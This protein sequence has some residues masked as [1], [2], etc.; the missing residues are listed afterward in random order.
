MR[1]IVGY[2]DTPSG[3]DALNLAVRLA[4]S[5][6]RSL[7]IVI[8]LRSEARAT[9]V[10][11]DAGYEKYLHQAAEEW[12]HHALTLVPRDMDVQGHIVYAESF[13]QGLLDASR[14]LEGRM[15][16]V[17]AARGGLLG[18]FTIGSVANALLHSA[19][20]P[21]ALAPEGSH[22]E[23]GLEGISRVTVAVG[24]RSGAKELVDAGILAAR[25][26]G[27]PLRLVSLVAL[28][29]DGVDTPPEVRARAEEHAAETVAYA[30]EHLPDDIEVT[31][32]TASGNRI[33]DAVAAL[34]WD[35]GE[36]VF[37]GSSRLAQP[38]QI[39]LG[40]TAAKMLRELPV[41][42][43]VVPRDSILTV[44]D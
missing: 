17:G 41:P 11:V 8:V 33:E 38:R 21:V 30:A 42:M 16:I 24:T 31:V 7:D 9:L 23:V 29:S 6:Q 2:T 4:R 43:V 25:G 18:R 27:V 40:T 20:V 10:P 28:D 36:V 37:V 32:L 22:A 5:M 12:L 44:E 3:E 1:Y 26:A 39:F 15:I 19:V 35:P 13:A 14:D 34:E